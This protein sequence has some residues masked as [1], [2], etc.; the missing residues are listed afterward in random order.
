[1]AQ[2]KP[3]QLSGKKSTKNS[4]LIKP[5]KMSKKGLVPVIAV[6]VLVGG[7]VVLKTFASGTPNRTSRS[8]KFSKS[9]TSGKFKSTDG[10]V[11]VT[12][13][14]N[15]KFFPGIKDKYYWAVQVWDRQGFYATVATSKK[16]QANGNRDHECY[17]GRIYK[18]NTYRVQFLDGDPTYN[19]TI[20]GSYYAS[21]FYRK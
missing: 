16:Y 8:V 14:F 9:Y 17:D 13:R 10:K 3:R 2:V 12:A 11:C 1:M 18:G 4:K 20:K 21:G 5:N 6:V 15:S 19:Y 7:F